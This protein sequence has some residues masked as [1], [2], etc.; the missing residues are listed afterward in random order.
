MSLSPSVPAIVAGLRHLIDHPQDRAAAFARYRAT[1][2]W[3][4]NVGRLLEVV[5]AV[6]T[7]A[8]PYPEA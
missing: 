4:V 2:S 3:E 8:L 6:R 5:D 1:T 7:A